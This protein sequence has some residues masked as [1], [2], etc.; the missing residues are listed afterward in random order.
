MTP[1]QW[2]VKWEWMVS[3]EKIITELTSIVLSSE[4]KIRMFI[5]ETEI[6]D[7]TRFLQ[8]MSLMQIQKKLLMWSVLQ[9]C[10]SDFKTRWIMFLETSEDLK[11]LYTLLKVHG[12]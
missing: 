8:L 2:G 9:S 3:G 4:N 11:I 1:R 6:E 10:W 12:W 7:F 5:K